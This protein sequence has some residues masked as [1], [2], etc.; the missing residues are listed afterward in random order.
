M[1]CKKIKNKKGFGYFTIYGAEQ[2]E[3]IQGI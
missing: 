3:K 2:N 1:F